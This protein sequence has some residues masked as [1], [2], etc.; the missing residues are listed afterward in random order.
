MPK[1]FLRLLELGARGAGRPLQGSVGCSRAP[2]EFQAPV[3]PVLA[4]GCVSLV[5]ALAWASGHLVGSQL[6][7]HWC[8]SLEDETVLVRLEWWLALLLS[9]PFSSSRWGL[10]SSLSRNFYFA[11]LCF[12]LVG[13]GV[14]V[15]GRFAHLV[16]RGLHSGVSRCLPVQGCRFQVDGGGRGGSLRSCRWTS[17]MRVF[18]LVLVVVAVFFLF[19]NTRLWTHARETQSPVLGL[20]RA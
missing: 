9:G 11:S 1:A 17:S 13:A 8:I 4:S 14:N 7:L 18:L 19:D 3:A 20:D 16:T 6:L 2:S 12:Y 15:Y 5:L 10:V